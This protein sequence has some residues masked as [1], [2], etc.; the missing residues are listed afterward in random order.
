MQQFVY[1]LNKYVL[2]LLKQKKKYIIY[3]FIV[4]FYIVDKCFKQSLSN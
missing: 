2:S 3:L 4:L 1:I